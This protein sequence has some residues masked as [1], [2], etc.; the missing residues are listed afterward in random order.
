M[1]DVGIVFSSF[2]FINKGQRR[3]EMERRQRT[4]I[5]VMFTAESSMFSMYVYILC[6]RSN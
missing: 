6:M 3:K 1:T 4:M 2:P 5:K